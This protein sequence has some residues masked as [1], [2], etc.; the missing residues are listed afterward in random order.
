MKFNRIQVQI[1]NGEPQ[2]T[3]Y[4]ESLW[5]SLLHGFDGKRVWI[6]V[7]EK[8]KIKRTHAQN[9]YYFSAYMNLVAQEHG[10]SVVSMHNYFRDEL[11]PILFP[12]KWHDK[13]TL[14]TGE[15]RHFRSKPSTTDLTKAEFSQYIMEIENI[16]G[17][18]A[19]PVEQII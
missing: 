12:D 6:E 1:E 14:S 4:Q 17:I 9:A 5:H 15:V 7:Y 18:T 19:P 11:L 2:M 8:E 10:N 3:H 16:T 13:I